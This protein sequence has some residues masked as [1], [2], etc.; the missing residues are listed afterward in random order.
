MAVKKKTYSIADKKVIVKKKI[1]V[2][3]KVIVK[4]KISTTADN[5]KL[6]EYMTNRYTDY[7]N[8]IISN[9]KYYNTIERNKIMAGENIYLKYSDN[10]ND[11][12][13]LNF[14]IKE[15]ENNFPD[16]FNGI[17]DNNEKLRLLLKECFWENYNNTLYFTNASHIYRDKKGEERESR[18]LYL[19]PRKGRF[20]EDNISDDLTLSFRGYISIGYFVIN[21]I[22]I[23]GNYEGCKEFEKEI[24]VIPHHANIPPGHRGDYLNE[25]INST[26]SIRMHLNNNLENWEGY[27]DWRE[28]LVKIRLV[29]IKY[30]NYYY[31]EDKQLIVFHLVSPSKNE[32]DRIRRY[33]IRE[34]VK[35]FDNKYS[36][37]RWVFRFN[38]RNR[39]GKNAISLGKFSMIIKEIS[40]KPSEK[41]IEELNKKLQNKK[42]KGRDFKIPENFKEDIEAIS[43]NPYFIEMAFELDQDTL[44]DIKD[45]DLS[46][47]EIKQYVEENIL[48]YFNDDGFVAL[49]AVGD[50]ALIRRL[51]E[52]IGSL[53]RDEGYCPNLPLWL[54]DIKKAEIPNINNV[55]IDKWLNRGIENNSGQNMAVR[56]MLATKD[57]CLIQGPPGTGKTTVIAEA[58]Y[59][60]ALRGERV[61]IAS[62]TNLA[63]DN[64]LERLAKEPIIRAIRLNAQKSTEDIAHMTENKVL[65]F[66]FSNISDKLKN[67][68]LNNWEASERLINNLD[69]YLR[70]INQYVS[71]IDQYT[72]KLNNLKEEKDKLYNEVSNLNEEINNIKNKNNDLNRIKHQINL[73]NKFI[74]ENNAETEFVLPKDYINLIL[75]NINNQL[76]SL[77]N[78]RIDTLNLN[79]DNMSEDILTRGLKEVCKNINHFYDM[80][81]NIDVSDGAGIS[82]E[83][84]LLDSKI[85]E[86]KDKINDENTSEEE[87]LKLISELRKLQKEKSNN[88]TSGFELKETYKSLLDE[89]IINE[90]NNSNNINIIKECINKNT[91]KV[92]E[93]KKVFDNIEE[94]SNTYKN[95]LKAEDTKELENQLKTAEG[96]I[97]TIEEEESNFRKSL[98]EDN[99]KI[100]NIKQETN[101]P[102]DTS[103]N[104]IYNVLS[105]KRDEAI[106]ILDN[107]KDFRNKFG[108]FIKDFND[109]LEKIDINYENEYFKDTYINSCNVVGM[110]CTE[111]I[112]TLEDKGFNAFD[113]VIIDEVSKATPPELLMPMLRG[114]K[115]ILVGDHRQLPP[116]FGEYEKS[117]K[118]IVDTIEDTD[119]N[120]QVKSILT[121]ENFKKYENMVTSSIFKA[122]FEQAPEEIKDSL[123]IQFRMH[124]H[125]MEIINRFYENR[126]K[127]GIPKDKEDT[128]KDHQLEIKRTNGLSFIKR[129]KHAYWIDSS[130]IKLSQNQKAPIY[131]STTQTSTSIHNVLEA[132]I[133]I[134][135]L[136]QIA[137]AYKKLNLE[138]KVTVGVI[139]LYQLQVNKIR[140]MLKNERRKFDFSAINIDINTVDRFQGKEKEIVIVS[141]VRNPQT[142]KSKSKHITAFERV[143]V[144][145]SRAQNALIIVG[146]KNLYEKLDVELPNM[147]REGMTKRKVYREILE[148]LNM[149]ACFFES[150]T[151]IDYKKSN[152]ILNE[153]NNS[154]NK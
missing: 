122:Y 12:K 16:I 47:E 67:E 19:R 90:Y 66:F 77:E 37:N 154:A 20:L 153:Y 1:L 130:E 125:I 30:F 99:K 45:R 68:Y 112:K 118:E 71:R 39:G 119:E 15:L 152:T 106:K 9:N 50:F 89:S 11:V 92:D 23:I 56:K 140:D 33:F 120:K 141:L 35:V 121:E 148:Y 72:A 34:K 24:N 144:A 53:K 22:S 116:L 145:F 93:I 134:E 7:K 103:N 129:D 2:D 57:V 43:D 84:I 82:S 109:R 8:N 26:E 111:N 102:E 64:A 105:S 61:L 52:S 78:I 86:I 147:D 59:Q 25:L 79:I 151:V 38:E 91:S 36:T 69:L 21:E 27:L 74:K 108:S 10:D 32:F 14:N 117:Y 127:A 142:G 51:R 139:S 138:K 143:N 17:Q 5:I 101:I 41:E 149:N 48:K 60:F 44:D 146:A 18:K 83:S 94:Y 98:N 131:E 136:K 3:K 46:K 63:V 124:S 87:S 107:Q 113:V 88:K 137:T 13:R 29:G 96:R 110:S 4:K 75:N 42:E 95:S 85:K 55:K 58:I 114:R 128:V 150:D 28:E 97:R 133:I 132:H 100:R 40:S 62:Q 65:S 73:F 31:N 115:V 54:F 123:L 80:K 76:H 81:K 126:L 6:D 49:S 135:L 70:D 104:E